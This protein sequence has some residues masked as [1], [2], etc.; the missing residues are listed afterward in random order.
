MT[1]DL[2]RI[3]PRQYQHVI[4]AALTNGGY[5]AI[6]EALHSARPRDLCEIWPL[7]PEDVE[8]RLWE[9]T[10]AD[11]NDHARSL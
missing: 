1:I 7:L 6:A 4:E 11:P 3:D 8:I 10:D 9:V 2:S 5:I